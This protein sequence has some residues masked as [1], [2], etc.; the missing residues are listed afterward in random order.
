MPALTR[1]ARRATSAF[2][3][4]ERVTRPQDPEVAAALRQR[5]AELP[6]HV[7]HRSQTIGQRIAGCEGTHGVF[8]RC[9]FAC[10]PCYHSRDA[11]KVRIDGEHTVSEIGRQMEFTRRVRG[12]GQYAQLIGGEVSLLGPDD[13]AAALAAMLEHERKPMSFTHGD[14]DYDYLRRLALNPDGS[15]RFDALAFAAHFDS[16]MFGR[17][18]IPLPADE[19]SL[20]P[21]RAR[22]CAMFARLRR[23]HGV[24]SHLAHNYTVTPRNVAQIPEVLRTAGR[25]GFHMFSFQPAAFVGNERR[26]KDDYGALSADAVWSRIEAGAGGRLPYRLFQTGDERCNRAAY[27]GWVG[28]RWVAL[29]DDRDPRDLRMRSALF[30]TLR[31]IDLAAPPAVAA[32]RLTRAFARRPSSVPIALGWSVRFARRA[33]LRELMRHGFAPVT[34]VM[35]RFMDAADVGEAWDAM[36]NGDEIS[37]ERIRETRERLEA[38]SYHFSHPETGR[39]IPACAQHAVFDPE[40]NARLARELPL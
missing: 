32:A 16:M 38:C 25:F 19:R 9:D 27:G 14:F 17:R 15:R 24:K 6:P 39:L 18:G 2:R 1:L 29:A 30:G 13:H 34:L 12:P 11:N 37:D 33:G 26:W 23:E 5:W 35:H 21:F 7:K 22:F 40:E 36:E 3:A 28:S 20:N 31:G 4:L 8:P 10:T